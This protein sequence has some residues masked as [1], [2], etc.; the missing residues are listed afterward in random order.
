MIRKIAANH[1]VEPPSLLW[2]WFMHPP[3][4]P[5]DQIGRSILILRGHR[6]LLDADL[7]GLYGVTTKRLN[8]QVKRNIDR[9]PADFM[10]QLTGVSEV[11]NCDVNIGVQH[12]KFEVAKCDLKRRSLHARRAPLSSLCFHGARRHHGLL[13]AKQ[14]ARHRNE[15]VRGPRLRAITRSTRLQ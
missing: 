10:F 11:A 4:V 7:A 2:D 6:V 9:F 1:L 14:S 15:R 13:C 5:V 12:F 8:E 3:P